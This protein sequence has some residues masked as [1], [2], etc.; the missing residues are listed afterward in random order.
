MTRMTVSPVILLAFL[1]VLLKNA[2]SFP[3]KSATIRDQSDPRSAHNVL[4]TGIDG[5][6]GS[7]HS[8]RET[9]IGLSTHPKFLKGSRVS[10]NELH[11]VVFVV[12]E[13]NLDEL[14]RILYDISD[15]HSSNYGNHMS[16]EEIEDLVSNPVA[17]QEVVNYLTAAGATV[18][19]GATRGECITARAEV[20]VWERMLNT[21]F[22]SYSKVG[23]ATVSGR[24]DFI[25]TEQY[26][27]PAG[28][29]DHVAFVMNTV[30]VPVTRFQ[31]D[32]LDSHHPIEQ[33]RKSRFSEA[34]VSYDGFTSI[35][36]MLARYN[37]ADQT[38]HPR[39][40]QAALELFGQKF[41][42]EDLVLFQQLYSLPIIPANKTYL[43]MVYTA[44]QCAAAGI[45]ICVE[46]NIDMQ[47]LIAL[48]NTP[49][50]HYYSTL[51]T[52]AEW[53]QF[54]ANAGVQPPLIISVSYGD[55]ERIATVGEYQLFEI[56][57]MKIGAM[58]S[59]ILISAGDDGVH[60]GP[61]RN[62]PSLCGYA[63]QY[64]TSCPYV[65]SVGA[66]QVLNSFSPYQNEYFCKVELTNDFSYYIL[67][68]R[69]L[70]SIFP[71][72]FVKMTEE[73]ESRV[74]AVS[75]QTTPYRRIK[76]LLWPNISPL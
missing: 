45:D 56:S 3:F 39:A 70:T 4:D 50:I 9:A 74:E 76:P 19:H 47:Y 52:F 25:R 42:P 64:P 62:D 58:G 21:E 51:N 53:A 63:P 17:Y 37:I 15:P 35:D 65:I 24:S 61:T 8:F 13:K 2:S 31:R 22:H 20:G 26:S 44:A 36:Q 68:Y 34:G 41:C 29:D 32:F 18:M 67:L 16:F 40:T 59:T 38:G 33:S 46:T 1:G 30:Q 55:D 11:E 23:V 7:L 49:T 48:A 6:K 66:T 27:V 71:K 69:A 28:L 73:A 60:V 75:P 72:Q 43:P 10:S 5:S 57:T 54:T 12:K 14:K